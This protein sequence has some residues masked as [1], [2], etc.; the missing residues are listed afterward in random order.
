MCR[1]PVKFPPGPRFSDALSS[2]G[3]A[4]WMSR[5]S[6]VREAGH[7]GPSIF[8][9]VKFITAPL[10]M[11]E[12][13]K[14][15]PLQPFY[16]I[17]SVFISRVSLS[18]QPYHWKSQRGF[19]PAPVLPWIMLKWCLFFCNSRNLTHTGTNNIGFVLFPNLT[20]PQTSPGRRLRPR[21]WQLRHSWAGWGCCRS[22][23]E[24]RF[25]L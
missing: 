18:V 12:L 6:G 23:E 5:L 16:P 15:F 7:L 24:G 8:C 1:T 3:A 19:I 25:W 17:T 10:D 4:E 14:M 20:Q 9:T 13:A 2:G 22:R 11:D 21:R